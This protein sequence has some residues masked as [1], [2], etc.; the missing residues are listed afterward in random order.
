MVTNGHFE[1]ATNRAL[2]TTSRKLKYIGNG[3]RI[4]LQCVG[5]IVHSPSMELDRN[6]LTAPDLYVA[7]FRGVDP[8]MQQRSGTIRR[9]SLLDTAG[10]CKQAQWSQREVVHAGYILWS[11]P[12]HHS[13]LFCL[14]SLY[15]IPC[16][17][18][19]ST[20][21]PVTHSL[22]LC[23]VEPVSNPL[24]S[25]PEH[26]WSSHIQPLVLPVEP[27][28]SP[29]SSLPHHWWSSHTASCSA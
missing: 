4:I 18:S 26:R 8:E 21:D 9:E 20:D 24:S 23:L 7:P 28:S 2:E 17:H 10:W 13:L 3:R 12:E 1:T 16:R 22:L 11:V 27:V 19:H 25:L 15:Q 14:W 29:L 5:R 6:R